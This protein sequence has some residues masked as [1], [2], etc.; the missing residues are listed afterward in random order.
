MPAKRDERFN[1]TLLGGTECSFHSILVLLCA[2]ISKLDRDNE[3]IPVNSDKDNQTQVSTTVG[4]NECFAGGKYKF[5]GMT[6]LF[7][8]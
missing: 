1:Y 6:S 3:I 4:A 2:Q 8:P 5:S 7:T